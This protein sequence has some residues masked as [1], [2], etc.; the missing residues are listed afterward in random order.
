M[1][2]YFKNKY[3]NWEYLL[4]IAVIELTI[5]RIFEMNITDSFWAMTWTLIAA[6]SAVF[7]IIREARL[8]KELKQWSIQAHN[9]SPRK[10]IL[11]TSNYK[12]DFKIVSIIKNPIS[13][14]NGLAKVL[15]DGEALWTGGI[16]V[17][18][19]PKTIKVLETMN[20]KEQWD[21]LVGIRLNPLVW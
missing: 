14:K 8:Y 9:T 5:F 11:R 10:A 19:N 12:E 1:K 21:W 7:M 20:P 17:D 6:V 3:V 2:K 18:V 16:L 13:E 4:L 15:C